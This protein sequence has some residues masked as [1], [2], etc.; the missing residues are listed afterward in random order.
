MAPVFLRR[1]PVLAAPMDFGRSLAGKRIFGDNKTWRGFLSG[2]LASLVIIK[3]QSSFYPF[4]T[5]FTF[6]NYEFPAIVWL[7]LAMGAGAILGDAAGSF[8]KR[9]LGIPPG[10]NLPIID[11]IDWIVGAM[12]ASSLFYSWS[13]QIWT[14]AILMF[15][16]LHPPVNILGYWLRLK[17]N[18]F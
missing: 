3:I 5:G 14:V 16:L 17:P 15:G 11:Q 10:G 7:G 13:P 8:L 9:R 4:P 12:L 2:L 6:I 1:L 18:K